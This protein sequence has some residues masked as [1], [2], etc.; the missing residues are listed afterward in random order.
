MSL[1]P[2]NRRDGN[3]LIGVVRSHQLRVNG[4]LSVADWIK[5]VGEA[6]DQRRLAQSEAAVGFCSGYRLHWLAPCTGFAVIGPLVE[7]GA[8]SEAPHQEQNRWWLETVLPQWV[9]VA[10]IGWRRTK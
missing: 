6:C 3:C 4:K 1:R 10:A 9:Q 2:G 8:A 5:Q 7:L